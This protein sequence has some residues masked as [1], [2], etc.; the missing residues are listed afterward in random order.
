[1]PREWLTV[2]QFL[3][4]YEGKVSRSTV[5]DRVRDRSLPSVKL[6]RKILIPSDALDQILEGDSDRARS[7]N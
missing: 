6:G 1:M 5:Y 7:I 2:K 4:R 3:K